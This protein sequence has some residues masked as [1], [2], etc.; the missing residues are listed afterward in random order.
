MHIHTNLYS[1]C[2][3]ID[4][5]QVLRRAREAGL[6]GIALTEHGIR[7]KDEEVARLK[8]DSGME[9]FVVIPGQE[10]ACYSKTGNFQGE[11][12]VFG[13]PKSLGSCRSVEEL[14]DLVHQGGGVVIAAHPFKIRDSGE[15]YYGSGEMTTRLP[16]DGL[17]IE[18]PSYDQRS[19][20]LAHAAM[21]T[22]GAAGI[23]CSDAHE[24]AHV[25]RCRTIFE[26]WV[27]DERALCS[28]IRS[29]RVRA[30]NTVLQM[31]VERAE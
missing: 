8:K 14:I 27:S 5:K 3:N 22:M 9:D 25:G 11:Y 29:G 20:D 30:V 2:S 23:G 24:L 4:P 6:D 21:E 7:W 28:Q 16:I 13:Y 18:H 31:E 26:R 10:V 19:R 1:G 17:E 12:L 15:G